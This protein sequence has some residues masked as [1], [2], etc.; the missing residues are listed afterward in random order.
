MT[1]DRGKITYRYIMREQ[2]VAFRRGGRSLRLADRPGNLRC[3]PGNLRE[4]LGLLKVYNVE[5]I[6][7]TFRQ[8]IIAL[9]IVLI[10]HAPKLPYP[11]RDSC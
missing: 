8:E 4:N 6:F 5:Q 3:L 2:N 9:A 7:A 10:Q 11:R 1:K